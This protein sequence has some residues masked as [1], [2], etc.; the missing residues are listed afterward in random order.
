MVN[1]IGKHV[2]RHRLIDILIGKPKYFF[3]KAP[4]KEEKKGRAYHVREKYAPYSR[5]KLEKIAEICAILGYCAG[6]ADQI[7]E[8]N[9]LEKELKNAVN[10]AKLVLPKKIYD[11][12]SVQKYVKQ[13][14]G[15][16]S[17][18]S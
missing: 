14:K 4:A 18:N 17:Y 16:L 8:K 9:T 7:K 12:D 1:Y 10:Q 11:S 2:N 5:K 6:F 15:C 3:R 13:I